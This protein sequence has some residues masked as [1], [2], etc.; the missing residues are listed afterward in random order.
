MKFNQ[1]EGHSGQPHSY[2]RRRLD[3]FAL[4]F[5]HGKGAANQAHGRQAHPLSP[6][7]KGKRA[8]WMR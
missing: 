3:L 1:L 8:L 6:N 5:T 2:D 4:I 7:V